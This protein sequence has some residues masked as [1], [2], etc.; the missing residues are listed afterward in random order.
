MPKSNS[1]GGKKP[2]FGLRKSPTTPPPSA[3]AFVG[4]GTAPGAS[5]VP[6]APPKPTREAAEQKA[7][8]LA[9]GQNSKTPP[10]SSA[11]KGR[12]LEVRADGSVKRKQTLYLDAGVSKKLAVYCAEEGLDISS[13]VTEAVAFFLESKVKK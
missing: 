10:P 8:P 2:D 3:D 5:E 7:A 1:G 4:L 12:K 9:E 13:V 6:T 11:P